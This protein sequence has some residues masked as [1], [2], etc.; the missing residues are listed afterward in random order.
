MVITKNLDK[1]TTIRLTLTAQKQLEELRHVYH[2]NYS[3]VIIKAIEQLYR[4]NFPYKNPLIKRER[5]K[6]RIDQEHDEN[7]D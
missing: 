2:E 6:V 1:I 3:R 5:V 4:K 7:N